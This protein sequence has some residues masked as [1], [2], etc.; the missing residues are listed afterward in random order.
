[1]NRQTLTFSNG[2]KLS[3]S[4]ASLRTEKFCKDVMRGKLII[5]GMTVMFSNP[6]ITIKGIS[7][8]PASTKRILVA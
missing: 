1:M 3:H 4:E 5:E 6:E 2:I 7:S 8:N